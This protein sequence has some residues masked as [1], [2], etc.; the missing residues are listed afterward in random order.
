VLLGL[1]MVLKLAFCVFLVLAQQS[2]LMMKGLMALVVTSLVCTVLIAFLHRLVPVILVSIFDDI[3]ALIVAIIAIVWGI[4]LL[5]MS[6]PSI[7]ASL[8]VGGGSQ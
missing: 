7:V 6:I 1:I 3:G 8:H 4:I 2:F 5:V